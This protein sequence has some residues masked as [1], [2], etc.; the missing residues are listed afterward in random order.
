MK[1]LLKDQLSA[2]L[3]KEK[4]QIVSAVL[5]ALLKYL[6]MTWQRGKVD[7]DGMVETAALRTSG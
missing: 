2:A 1:R 7:V 3:S 4:K 5:S 6:G